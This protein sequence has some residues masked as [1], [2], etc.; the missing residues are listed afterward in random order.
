MPLSIAALSAAPRAETPFP[1]N[2]GVFGRFHSDGRIPTVLQPGTGEVSLFMG[3]FVTRVN[4]D[5]EFLGRSAYHAGVTYTI[6]SPSDGIDP[7]D[8]MVLFGSIVKPIVSDK[9]SFDATFVA[10]HQQADRYSGR[11]PGPNPTDAAGNPVADWATATHLTFRV[12]DR[13]SFSS[14]WS[15]YLAPSAIF[16]PDPSFRLTTSPLIRVISP[17]LGPAPAFIFRSAVEMHW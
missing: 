11:I 13:G 12:E 9:L 5:Y 4:Q 8:K 2:G 6:T 16:S 10:F 15:G 14:G 1:F 7:G 17:E 3:L